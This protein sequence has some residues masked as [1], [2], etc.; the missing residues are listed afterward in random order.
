[1][2]A[3]LGSC[4][5]VTRGNTTGNHTT[6]KKNTKQIR[7]FQAIYLYLSFKGRFAIRFERNRK[8]NLCG[9][10]PIKMSIDFTELK[11]SSGQLFINYTRLYL[12][13]QKKKK[14][15][16]MKYEKIITWIQLGIAWLVAQ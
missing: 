10:F 15:T 2:C 9:Y 14:K 11:N 13:I 8:L 7:Y 3:S 1:M 5:H 16:Y 12:F 4:D 6:I